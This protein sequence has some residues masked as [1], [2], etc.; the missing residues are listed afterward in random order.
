MVLDVRDERKAARGPDL[1]ESGWSALERGPEKADATWRLAAAASDPTTGFGGR[2]VTNPSASTRWSERRTWMAYR[3]SF[4]AGCE[5]F[6]A[7]TASATFMAS[8]DG[9]RS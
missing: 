2:W 9:T 4:F 3:S 7:L 1:A 8:K 6:S 5:A